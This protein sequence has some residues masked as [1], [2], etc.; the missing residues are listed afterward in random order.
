MAVTR[1]RSNAVSALHSS[2]PNPCLSLSK[3]KGYVCSDFQRVVLVPWP[4]LEKTNLSGLGTWIS[5]AFTKLAAA[6]SFGV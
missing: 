2:P 6:D 4:W 5:I 3:G 1:Y